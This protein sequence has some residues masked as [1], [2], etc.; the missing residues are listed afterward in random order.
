[1]MM[2]RINRQCIELHL[3]S[4]FFGFYLLS[5]LITQLNTESDLVWNT[6]VRIFDAKSCTLRK[7][8]SFFEYA[9]LVSFQVTTM[10]YQNTYHLLCSL[11]DAY[12]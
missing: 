7:G 6:F 8:L 12:D 3:T 9:Y 5:T 10:Q 1:M 2:L 11:L 4:L